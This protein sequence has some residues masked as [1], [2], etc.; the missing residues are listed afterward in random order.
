MCWKCLNLLLAEW[1]QI[2][3]PRHK[4]HVNLIIFLCIVQLCC[5]II[6]QMSLR[7]VWNVSSAAVNLGFPSLLSSPLFY[8]IFFSRSTNKPFGLRLF[9]WFH[10][11]IKLRGVYWVHTT[12]IYY[13]FSCSFVLICCQRSFLCCHPFYRDFCSRLLADVWK[14]VNCFVLGFFSV[15]DEYIWYF[16]HHISPITVLGSF[17]SQTWA[18]TG[19]F[20]LMKHFY[21][22]TP[23][24]LFSILDKEM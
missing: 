3:R 4:E 10:L 16:A 1:N 14:R 12:E 15:L 8:L 6:Q 24:L 18:E 23:L 11:R 5:I 7:A 22:Y 19:F 21:C 2:Q 13:T 20:F 17:H 9:C